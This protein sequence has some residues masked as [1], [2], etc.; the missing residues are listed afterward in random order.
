MEEAGLGRAV[1]SGVLPQF[2]QRTSGV[3]FMDKKETKDSKV[4]AEAEVVLTEGVAIASDSADTSV[5][6]PVDQTTSDK[7]INPNE[8]N[9][10]EAVTASADAVHSED[11]GADLTDT[12]K[13]D[14]SE[15]ESEGTKPT[16][17]AKKAKKGASGKER[18]P[19]GGR[20]KGGERMDRRVRSSSNSYKA[21]KVPPMKTKFPLSLSVLG[22]FGAS[23]ALQYLPTYDEDIAFLYQ[24]VQFGMYP[25]KDGLQRVDDLSLL[26][27]RHFE[28]VFSLDSIRQRI[29]NLKEKMDKKQVDL[30]RL[31]RENMRTIEIEVSSPHVLS[32]F[33]AIKLAD[34]ITMLN[35]MAW[36]SGMMDRK[37]AGAEQFA[38]VRLIEKEFN[39]I[40]RIAQICRDR[41][42]WNPFPYFEP[43]RNRMNK[44]AA[45]EAAKET[46]PNE[47][48]ERKV[49]E[50]KTADLP[51]AK[52]N[53][54]QVEDSKAD[55][56]AGLEIFS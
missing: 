56:D 29:A 48:D 13:T 23:V 27:S 39:F 4:T 32:F 30:D 31:Y 12:V 28:Y 43:V 35:N 42:K 14:A 18:N 11:G 33:E 52:K 37:E 36:I 5:D 53:T 17:Q 55:V 19:F 8:T 47:T 7:S 20:E 22:D 3:C 1:V 46:G 50:K 9:A 41:R 40:N 25:Y 38:L 15:S 34:E 26:V 21:L 2:A 10:E 24:H 44:E 51:V 6:T 54:D 16:G 45:K 49:A